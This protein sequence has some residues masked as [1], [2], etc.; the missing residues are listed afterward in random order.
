MPAVLTIADGRM[1]I[2]HFYRDGNMCDPE[3]TSRTGVVVWLITRFRFFSGRNEF[4]RMR[5]G[6]TRLYGVM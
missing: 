1:N 5:V 3:A 4:S 6:L 2:D